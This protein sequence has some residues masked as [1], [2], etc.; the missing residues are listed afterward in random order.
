VGPRAGV[1]RSEKCRSHR[2]SIP[3]PSSPQGIAIP[4]EISQPTD[5]LVYSLNFSTSRS[6][7]SSVRKISGYLLEEDQLRFLSHLGIDPT[8]GA[9]VL[10]W[11][12]IFLSTG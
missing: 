10:L 4:T 3:G 12:N 11:E 1:D 6:R 5:A 8:V 2:D 7:D 9:S